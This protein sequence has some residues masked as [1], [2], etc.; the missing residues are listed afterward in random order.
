MIAST[1]GVEEAD[2]C[3][4]GMGYSAGVRGVVRRFRER[5][6]ALQELALRWQSVPPKEGSPGG[7]TATHPGGVFYLETI[8]TGTVKLVHVWPGWGRRT[9]GSGNN[10]ERL[11]SEALGILRRGGPFGAPTIA[12]TVE[13][14]VQVHEPQGGMRTPVPDGSEIRVLLLEPHPV[15]VRIWPDAKFAQ[16]PAA[17]QN[18]PTKLIED[19]AEYLAF[20]STRTLWMFTDVHPLVGAMRAD[21][22][23]LLL[24]PLRADRVALLAVEGVELLGIKIGSWDEIRGMDADPWIGS[25]EPG[26]A[27]PTAQAAGATSGPP[28]S[29]KKAKAARPASGAA[30]KKTVKPGSAETPAGDPS[31]EAPKKRRRHVATSPGGMP[32]P[33]V[34]RVRVKPG[35]AA[36]ITQHLASVAATLPAGELGAAFAVELLR[37]LEAAALSN[38]PTLT[39]KTIEL[40]SLLHKK[41]FLSSIPT[42]QTGRAA[43]LLLVDRTPLVRRLHYRRW[44][45]AFGD[46]H[47]PASELRARLGPITVE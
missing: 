12:R 19:D 7:E 15:S 36:A 45:F 29:E 44:C 33:R 21:P 46:I 30:A 4:A 32:G 31:G 24:C 13:R 6:A 14:I 35:L 17:G 28:K 25:L 10:P 23:D 1:G 8:G 47:D 26:K 41:G 9:L 3:L 27:P 5:T 34:R 11:R 37:A 42:D 38:L 39:G 43:F 2:E 16:M 40:F 22:Y 20:G 18:D